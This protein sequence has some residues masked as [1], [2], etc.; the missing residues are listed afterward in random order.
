MVNTSNS[1]D[2]NSIFF[3]D[4]QIK[5]DITVYSEKPPSNNNACRACDMETFM[6]LKPRE[7]SDGFGDDTDAPE[8]VSG[9]ARDTRGQLV[10]YLNAMQAAQYRK[11]GFGVLIVAN[12]CRLIRH[13]R[14]GIEITPPFRYDDK[15]KHPFLQEFFWRFSHASPEARGIDTS[16]EPMPRFD[17]LWARSTLDAKNGAMWK[18]QVGERSFYV[19]APFT[20]SHHYPFGRGTRCFVA[21]DCDT[22]Q[23]C[24]LKD[25]WRLDGYHPEGEVYERLH[26]NNVRNIPNVLAAGDVHDHACGIFP[27]GWYLP[28]NSTIRVHSHY[29]LVLDVV[30]QPIVD[31]ESTYALTRYILDALEGRLSR[32]YFMLCP[33]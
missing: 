24:L 13:T 29:R 1:P 32:L 21:V 4:H 27:D 18:V 23:K 30:G 25:S 20:R 12:K 28:T 9:E 2:P 22:Q 8:K 14:S 16:F 11:H 5:P 6:E 3:L 19:T 33:D 10:T 17:A 7:D 15:R 31:F 26:A